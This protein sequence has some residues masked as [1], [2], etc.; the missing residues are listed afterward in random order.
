MRTIYIDSQNKCHVTDDGT[1]K[2]VETA[3][4]DGKC[5]AYVEGFCAEPSG[6]GYKIYPWKNYDELLSVQRQYETDLLR[7]TDM[8]NALAI[9]MGGDMA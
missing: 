6:D 3:V 1:M 5:D 8:E 2:A 9:L 4:F 7:I